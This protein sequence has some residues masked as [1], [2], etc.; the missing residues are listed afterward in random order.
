MVFNNKVK[1][2]GKIVL[3]TNSYSF[4]ITLESPLVP[5]LSVL[6]F[7]LMLE[8]WTAPVEDNTAFCGDPKDGP[9]ISNKF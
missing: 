8:A 6:R 1:K 3:P 7:T 5:I 4:E 9:I 2:L